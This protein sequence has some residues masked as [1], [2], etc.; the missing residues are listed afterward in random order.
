[1]WLEDKTFRWNLEGF[2][3]VV[4]SGIQNLVF[5]AGQGLSQMHV[6]GIG[7]QAIT[8][9][10]LNFDCAFFHEFQNFLISEDQTRSRGLFGFAMESV[11]FHVWI[12]FLFLQTAGGFRFVL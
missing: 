1:M 12:V 8:A 2:D 7:A 3:Q 4:A 5:V 11:L 6:V 9:K 10:R